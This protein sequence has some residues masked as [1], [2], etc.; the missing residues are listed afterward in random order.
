[1]RIVRTLGAVAVAVASMATVSSSA[2]AQWSPAGIYTAESSTMMFE[3]VSRNAS[4]EHYLGIFDYNGGNPLFAQSIFS[5]PPD[6]P[7]S[8]SLIS[9]LTVGNQYVLGLF[10]P[11]AL[12]R[13][14]WLV[15]CSDGAVPTT[16]FSDGT[17]SP[18]ELP[19][20]GGNFL[21]AGALDA[22]GGMLIGM[23][24]NR[25]GSASHGLGFWSYG[26]SDNDFNDMVIR[27]TATTVTPEPG[28]IALLGTG[29][30]ALGGFGLKRRR[31]HVA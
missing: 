14:C 21:F 2:K 28:T 18:D 6:G 26:P 30:L 23:E 9:G 25:D 29:L 1:M 24:D 3:F 17:S 15:I 31:Q 13:N 12:D 11:D 5:A 8:T 27:A 20:S 19:G 7:G 10:T 16:Y 4:F 22:N